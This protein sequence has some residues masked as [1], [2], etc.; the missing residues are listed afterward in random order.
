MKATQPKKPTRTSLP[1]TVYL[2]PDE[3]ERAIL[4]AEKTGETLSAFIRRA[5]LKEVNAVLE[6]STP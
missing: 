6:P 5:M 4:A 1:F 2:E 3:K